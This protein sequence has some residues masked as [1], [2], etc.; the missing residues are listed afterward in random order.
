MWNDGDQR[1]SE[2]VKLPGL[3]LIFWPRSDKYTGGETGHKFQIAKFNICIVFSIF[4]F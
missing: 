1:L 4:E 2:N 3:N